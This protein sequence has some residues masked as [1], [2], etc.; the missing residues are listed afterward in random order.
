MPITLEDIVFWSAVYSATAFGLML[1]IIIVMHFLMPTSVLEKYFKPPHFREFECKLFTG[2]PYAPMRTIM[3]M[4]VL[5]FPSRGKKRKL[6]QAYLLVPKWY[7]VSS[8]IV[9]I[10]TLSFGGYFLLVIFGFYAYSK[11]VAGS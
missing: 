6:T 8:A 10:S 2:I 4:T 9:L 7:R 11:L 3:F 5:A 1:F